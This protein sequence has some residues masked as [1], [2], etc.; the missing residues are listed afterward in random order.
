MRCG[1]RVARYAFNN[2]GIPI[3]LTRN[4]KPLSEY[5]EQRSEYRSL[6]I[7]INLIRVTLE[8]TLKALYPSPY[9]FFARNSQHETRNQ[10]LATRN[11]QLESIDRPPL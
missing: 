1:L 8:T 11:T 4:P 7:L 3:T 10:L 5:R 9:A 2:V 6:K